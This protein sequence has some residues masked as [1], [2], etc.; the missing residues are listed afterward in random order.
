M[1]PYVAS[2]LGIS[3]NGFIGLVMVCEAPVRRH[4]DTAKTPRYSE[5]STVA[6]SQIDV[7]QSQ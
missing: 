5:N 4:L 3:P 6:H 7:Y 1:V 2:L